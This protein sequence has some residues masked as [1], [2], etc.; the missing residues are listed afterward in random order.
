[1]GLTGRTPDHPA[2]WTPAILDSVTMWLERIGLAI[3]DPFVGTG[4]RLGTRADQLGLAFTGTD[5]E[6]WP[7]AD[8]R[9]RVGDSADPAT[10]PTWPFVVVTSPVYF[11]NR[12][13]SDYVNGPT[14]QTKLA[15][16][17]A[18]GISL[19][20][21]LDRRN[22]ARLCREA[23]RER[24]DAAHRA[25]A[26]LWDEWAIV[27]IDGPIAGQWLHKILEPVG[28]LL[29]ERIDVATPRLGGGIA[30]ADKRSGFET[31]L[32]VRRP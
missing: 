21:P 13:L 32:I 30:G 23:S 16:R 4:V 2:R 11:G 3:H 9:V 29:V 1:V 14:K 20:R 27:N 8:P 26:Q 19:G 18:Y 31:V 7:G 17:H 6:A 25:I 12:I 5:I 28:Y 10:Y 15:G 22:L 24:H